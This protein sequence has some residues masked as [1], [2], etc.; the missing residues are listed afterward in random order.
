M[1]TKDHINCQKTALITGASSGIGYELAKLFARDGYNLVLVA[2]SKQKL[3][4]LADELTE[5]FGV[6]VKV[7]AKDLALATSPDEIYME[8]QELSIN[9]HF[10]INNAGF[11]TYGFFSETDSASELQMLQVNIV[12][13]THLTKLFLNE[14]L[15][16]GE[17]K[18]LN[19]A[20]TA[21]FQP[22]PL[23]AVYYATK[24][25]VLS[26]SEAIA[27]ELRGSGVTVTA[28]CPGPTKSGFQKRADMEKSKLVSGQKIMDAENVAMIGYRGL[29]KNQ[30]VVVPGLKNQLLALSVRFTPRNLVTK[31]VRN[32]QSKVSSAASSNYSPNQTKRM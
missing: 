5:K 9:I 29:M 11:A 14:M 2:R 26:F 24:A 30:A 13:L 17:G 19:V 27:N 22:G 12:S 4:Q 20:S 28:L 18:I 10:L 16:Q 21:A 23:M 6:S 15:K 25:Y 32:M 31:L 8:V 3:I 7:I 1:N